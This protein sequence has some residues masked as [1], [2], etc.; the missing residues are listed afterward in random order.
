MAPH[1]PSVASYSLS[2]GI[3]EGFVGFFDLVC[4]FGFGECILCVVVSSGI[5][6]TN[7]V[8]ESEVSLCRRC[9]WSVRGI[10]ALSSARLACFDNPLSTVNLLVFPG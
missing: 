2:T 6:L 10:I 7:L 8:R 9:Q 1:A 4:V 3:V 5:D